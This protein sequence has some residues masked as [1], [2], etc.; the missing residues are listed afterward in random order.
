MYIHTCI[1]IYIYIDI[2]SLFD[3]ASLLMDAYCDKHAHPHCQTV[4]K[5][6]QLQYKAHM[7]WKEHRVHRNGYKWNLKEEAFAG[8]YTHTFIHLYTHTLIHS[9]THTLIHS[10][11]HTFTH[12]YAYMYINSYIC[13][14]ICT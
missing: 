8:I 4:L 9:Y 10:Y 13:M 2:D 7:R 1:Y 11:T 5:R 14:L 12:I 3:D 6:L